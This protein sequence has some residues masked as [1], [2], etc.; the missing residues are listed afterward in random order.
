MKNLL[1]TLICCFPVAAFSQMEASLNEDLV[2][3]LSYNEQQVVQLAEAIPADKYDWRP[4]DG[5]RSVS[6]ALMHMAA[7]NY[8]FLNTMGIAPPD[9]LDMQNMESISEKEAVI[10]ALKNS[11]AFTREKVPMIEDLDSKVQ[12]GDQEMSKRSALLILLEHTGEH[13]GQMIAYARMN[14][15]TPPWSQQ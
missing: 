7:A 1:I 13:K 5:V 3:I 11:F 2:G 10:E 4:S 14:D 6:E 9:G 15:I 12:F 8:F